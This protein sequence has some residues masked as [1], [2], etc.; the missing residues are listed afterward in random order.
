MRIETIG[1][2]TLYLADCMDILPTLGKVDAVITDPPY[3]TTACAWDAVIPFGPMWDCLRNITGD[4]SAIIFTASQPF[5]SAL[6]MSRLDMF[7][8]S[9][10]Y[11]KR[12]ASNF[13]Q[14]S[15][16]PMKEHEDVLVFGKKKV[17]YY[18]IKEERVGSGSDRVQSQFSAASRH[19]SGEFV[20]AMS[21]EFSATADELRFPSSVQEFNNRAKGD[22]GFHPTQ[23]PVLLLEYLIKTYTKEGD[24]V[25]DFTMGSGTAGVACANTGRKFI[26]IDRESKYF[27]IACE[28]IRSAQSKP[29][30]VLAQS[31]LF[32]DAQ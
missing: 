10:I 24:T 11:K 23:K 12:C 28:R 15:Y 27:D 8:H 29:V 30:M 5:T 2:A 14:A 18:P 13:A 3:G 17:R 4:D 20:G 26:G 31:D 9:W 32:G 21:G 16:A 19:K 22:R 6:V 25:L 1:N 7:R